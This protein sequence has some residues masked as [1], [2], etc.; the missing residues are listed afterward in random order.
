MKQNLLQRKDEITEF[1]LELILKQI[2]ETA[3]DRKPGKEVK[4][5]INPY[6]EENIKSLIAEFKE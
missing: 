1:D 4:M 6:L 2:K 3:E 5:N